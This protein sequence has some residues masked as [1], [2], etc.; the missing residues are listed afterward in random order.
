MPTLR[1]PTLPIQRPP[2]YAAKPR[3]RIA[4]EKMRLTFDTEVS[5]F[6]P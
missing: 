3:N 5:K 2:K 4:S 6:S 1:G